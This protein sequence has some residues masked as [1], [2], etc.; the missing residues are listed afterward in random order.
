MFSLARGSLTGA[1]AAVLPAWLC[2]LLASVVFH[3]AASKGVQQSLAAI[4]KRLIVLPFL[5]GG[6]LVLLS[7]GFAVFISAWCLDRFRRRTKDRSPWRV[8]LFSATAS[9]AASIPSF[10]VLWAVAKAEWLDADLLSRT[11]PPGWDRIAQVVYISVWVAGGAGL[12]LAVA[13]S[14]WCISARAVKEERFCDDCGQYMTTTLFPP[15]RLG[16]TIAVARA[17]NQ[18][19][20]TIAA[21]LLK[22]PRGGDGGVPGGVRIDRC[23]G[24]GRG[25]L[26]LT[27]AYAV[28]SK[29]WKGKETTTH[30]SW[31]AASVT[32]DGDEGRLF[33]PVRLGGQRPGSIFVQSGSNVV[34]KLLRALGL[35][36]LQ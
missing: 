3:W 23:L 6:A 14:S 33:D 27:L 9:L 2:M 11:Y 26:E 16:R 32:L 19:H 35:G 18:G 13:A 29:D 21:H 24:C 5:L 15:L 30:V 25:Y 4:W 10:L 34:M 22:R 8:G 31:R 17:V 7:L 36:E 20:L 1:A 28:K 12:V